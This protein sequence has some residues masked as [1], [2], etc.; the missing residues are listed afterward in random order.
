MLL[1]HEDVMWSSA[2]V[3]IKIWEPKK[4]EVIDDWRHHAYG[5]PH[6]SYPCCCMHCYQYGSLELG[7][8]GIV[9]RYS[10]I[11]I[12]CHTL[13]SITVTWNPLR[14][15][16]WPDCCVNVLRNGA[17]SGLTT[18]IAIKLSAV[19]L[20]ASI[21]LQWQLKAVPAMQISLCLGLLPLIAI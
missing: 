3:A 15:H 14:R 10:D 20:I 5:K 9:I 11:L 12:L 18:E 4:S 2:H 21:M 16:G 8:N 13:F 7:G 19:Q 1:W 6:E 17:H